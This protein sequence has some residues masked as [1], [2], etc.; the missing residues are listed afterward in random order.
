MFSGANSDKPV[1]DVSFK[2]EMKT[3]IARAFELFISDKMSQG[4]DG[5]VLKKYEREL[6]RFSQFMSRRSRQF[7]HEILEQ[8]VLS[9]T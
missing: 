7:P 9:S 6:G 1:G 8:G 3:T 2:A 4:L 5:G